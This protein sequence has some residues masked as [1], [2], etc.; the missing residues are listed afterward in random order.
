MMSKKN[1]IVALIAVIAASIFYMFF[2][3]KNNKDAAKELSESFEKIKFSE[4]FNQEGIKSES[5]KVVEL[6]SSGKYKELAENSEKE[7]KEL[8]SSDDKKVKKEFE[9]IDKI[10]KKKGKLKEVNISEIQ[11]YKIKETKEDFAL[12]NLL[13]KYEEGDVK[14]E[15]YFTK[16]AKLMAFKVNK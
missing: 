10:L 3:N 12:V 8:L 5:K 13:A 11:A 9:K 16:D 15:L 4:E 2:M 14:Y 1:R 6:I 7:L